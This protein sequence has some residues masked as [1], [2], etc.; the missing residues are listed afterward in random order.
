MCGIPNKKHKAVNI[1]DLFPDLPE[2]QLNE[3]R[4]VLEDYCKL[5]LQIFD[6]IERERGGD[7][8]GSLPSS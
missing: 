7:F 5:A 8:D 4:A 1:S 3:V 6:R 2:S